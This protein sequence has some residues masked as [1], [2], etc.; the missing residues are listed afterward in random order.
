MSHSVVKLF[1]SPYSD[2]TVTVP[3]SLKRA[4]SLQSV[5]LQT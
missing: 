2:L 3:M 4:H 5:F 1:S